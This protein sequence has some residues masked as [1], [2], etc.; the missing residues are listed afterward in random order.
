MPSACSEAEL[1]TLLTEVQFA[2]NLGLTLHA[3]N[4]AYCSLDVPFQEAFERPGGLVSGHVLMTA[5]DV[6]IWLAIKTRLGLTDNSLTAEMKT[7]FLSAARKSSFRCTAR[8]L[9][10]GRRLIYGVA[11]CTDRD[12]RLLAHHTVTYIR[13]ESDGRLS[14]P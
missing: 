5:A 1:R 12:G 14:H 11:E 10:F 8:I 13:S 6:A 9:K 7:N 4:D 3:I 2:R